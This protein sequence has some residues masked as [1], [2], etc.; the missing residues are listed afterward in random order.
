VQETVG[1]DFLGIIVAAGDG[2]A[3]DG[4]ENGSHV[5]VSVVDSDILYYSEDL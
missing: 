3:D 5:R 1:D 2:E 4:P